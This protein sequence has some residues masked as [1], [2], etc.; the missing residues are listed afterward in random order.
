MMI[1]SRTVVHL[2]GRDA[3]GCEHTV[4]FPIAGNLSYTRICAVA[5]SR[6]RH[7]DLTPEDAVDPALLDHALRLRQAEAKL[8]MLCAPP[9]P[10]REAFLA[11]A[12]AAGVKREHYTMDAKVYAESVPAS[13][14][15]PSSEVLRGLRLLA[16]HAPREIG[17]WPSSVSN[18]EHAAIH[19]AR[20]WLKERA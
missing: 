15:P 13:A 1:T 17:A 9:D 16:H 19:D 11:G 10:I 2:T 20:A 3:E 14:R 4:D 7:E 6:S 8:Q 5:H 12:A 18:R